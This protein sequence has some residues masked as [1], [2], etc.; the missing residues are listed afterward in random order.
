MQWKAVETVDLPFPAGA[1]AVS[2]RGAPLALLAAQTGCVK[3]RKE[4]EKKSRVLLLL[5]A[6]NLTRVRE[7]N[8]FLCCSWEG[9]WYVGVVLFFFMRS[10]CVTT[11]TTM[12]RFLLKASRMPHSRVAK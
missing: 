9:C 7:K 8:K 11:T 5:L 12:A 3:F 10:P 2:S 1:G 4:E 6:L